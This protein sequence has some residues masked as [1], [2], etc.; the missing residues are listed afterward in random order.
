MSGAPRLVFA[1]TPDFA[2]PSLQALLEAGHRPVAVYTQPDRRAGR[3]R[4][5]RP[6]PVKQQAEAQGLPVRQ[7]ESLRDPRA[8]AELAELAPDLMVVIAYGLILPQ[9]VLQI[10]ALGCVNLH[11]SLLPRWRGA[12]PIQRAILAGDDETGVCLMR[13]EAGLDT[14]PVLAR[15]RCPI[16][17]RETGGSLHDRLAALAG[18][19]LHDRLDDLLADRLPAQPQPEAGVCYADKLRKDE[20]WLD[21]RRDARQL[22]RQVRA[23][24][25]WPV[26]Q[27]LCQGQVLRVWEAEPVAAPAG[28][29][30]PGT[31]VRA[32]GD[33]IVVVAGEGALRLQTLQAAGGR[34]LG[35]REFLNGRALQAGERLG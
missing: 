16:G 6:S 3:G 2:V 19:L 29:A 26:A 28:D 35:V 14:G 24:N 33:G 7:P 1:G 17:P 34:P 11:A 8:Q 25:P 31:V 30:A 4:R 15:A 20:A 12:A 22:D 32:D 9:A 27:T 21:W 10:P 23:F 5:P 18:T 13:M